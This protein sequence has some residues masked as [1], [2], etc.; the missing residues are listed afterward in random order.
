MDL[1]TLLGGLKTACT[2]TGISISPGEAR[3]LACEAGL[4]PMV[5]GGRSQ[6]LDV[7]RKNRFHTPAQRIAMG[8]RDKCCT[9]QGM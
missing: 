3:R 6:P 1:E 7:G 9:A 4:I 2:H 5:L 8:L